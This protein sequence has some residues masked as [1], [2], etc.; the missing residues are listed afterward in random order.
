MFSAEAIFSVN[1]TFLTGPAGTG[2]TTQGVAHLK[3]LLN[4]GVLP[5]NILILLPQRT[6]GALYQE[7][8]Q[9]PALNV[10]GL[11]DVVTMDGLAL[12]SLNLVWPQIAA[13]AGFGRPTRRPVF[14][15]IETAQY[16]MAQV[17]QPMMQQGYFD[18]NVVSVTITLPRLMS[19]LLDNLEKAALIGLPYTQVETRLK[20]ALGAEISSRVAFEHAQACV[21]A[22]REFCLRN[23]LLDFSLRVEIFRNYVWANPG[24]RRLLTG[25]Y[26]HLIVDNLEEQNPFTHRILQDWLPESD[27]ALLIFDEDAGYRIFL[28]ANR[29]T[30]QDLAQYCRRVERRAQP[31]TASPEILELGRQIGLSLGVGEWGSGEVGEWDSSFVLRPSSFAWRYWV[32][33]RLFLRVEQRGVVGGESVLS[34]A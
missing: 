6:G 16:Y 29:R 31:F 11:V 12:R 23:N 14:L 30:A 18:P 9:D 5:H 4:E 20:S 3:T 27:S 21:I 33:H 19:Q 32:G 24:L 28:G 15:T 10:P 26:R 13:P 2:K 22:F 1:H 7:A 17:I 25:R 8:L 34:I